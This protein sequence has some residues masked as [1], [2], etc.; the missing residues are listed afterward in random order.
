MKFR[1]AVAAVAAA[2]VL[3]G[4][5]CSSRPAEPSPGSGSPNVALYLAN[6]FAALSS[7]V[8]AHE[9]LDSSEQVR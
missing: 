9:A 1:L 3:L 5:G 6:S 8:M 7:G 2:A 4:A